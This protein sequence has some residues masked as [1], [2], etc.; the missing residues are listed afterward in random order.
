MVGLAINILAFLFLAV[1]GIV[2]L[3]I[4][5]A[6]FLLLF[7]KSVEFFY[8]VTGKDI[9]KPVEQKAWGED[10]KGDRRIIII[11]AAPL[12]IG[13]LILIIGLLTGAFKL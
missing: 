11:L 7:G 3:C 8:D 1:V 13:F 6:G 4:V 9:N 5:G 2:V 10:P 12:V